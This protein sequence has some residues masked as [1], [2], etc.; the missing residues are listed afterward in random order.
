MHLLANVQQVT[1]APFLRAAIAPGTTVYTDEYD[2][3]RRLKEWGYEHLT[4]HHGRG[5]YARDADGHGPPRRIHVNTMEGCWS[6]LR[7]WLRPHRGISLVSTQVCESHANASVLPLRSSLLCGEKRHLDHFYRRE[8]KSAEMP[9]F[10]TIS[11]RVETNEAFRKRS[12]PS[13]SVSFSSSTT[14]ANAEKHC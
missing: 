5:E 4:V 1:I 3:Y 10:P 13:T 6:L 11:S 12:C 7:S 2:I 8:A 9:Q 14:H